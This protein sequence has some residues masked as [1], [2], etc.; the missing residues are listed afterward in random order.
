MYLTRKLTSAT[1]KLRPPMDNPMA[2]AYKIVIFETG[3]ASR[4]IRAEEPRQSETVLAEIGHPYRRTRL[5]SNC[6]ETSL[7][8]IYLP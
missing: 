4:R 5:A 3:L 6:T 2:Q 1:N 8:C 7:T